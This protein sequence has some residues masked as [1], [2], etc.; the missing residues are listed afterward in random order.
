MSAPHNPNRARLAARLR[1]VRAAAGLSGTALAQRLGWPQPRVSK[2]ETG[3]QTPN[4]DDLAAWVAATG[5]GSEQ[6]AELAELLAA[7]RVEYSTWHVTQRRPGGLAGKHADRGRWEAST[8]KIAEY[9]PGLFPGLVQTSSY[10]RELLD[11]PLD[12]VMGISPAENE[13]LVGERIKRQDILYQ[14]G[15]TI[16][17]VVGEAALWA[18][19]GSTD[20]LLNQLDRL[21]TFAE[22]PSLELGVVPREMMPIPPLSN[23]GVYDEDFVTVETLTGEQR[24]DEPVEVAVYVRAFE[25]LHAAALIGDAAVELIKQVSAEIRKSPRRIRS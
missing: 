24:I 21:I 4:D 20:T 5:A 12:S 23:F 18:T 8:T 2:L 15:R 3:K 22:L 16:Q 6:A 13:A 1:A 11:T 10:A 25:E 19:P 7:A 14:P 9:Q 17:V